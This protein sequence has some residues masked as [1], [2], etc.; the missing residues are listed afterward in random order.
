MPTAKVKWQDCARYVPTDKTSCTATTTWYCTCQ[1]PGVRWHHS[2]NAM[3]LLVAP[4]TWY[5]VGTWYQVPCGAHIKFGTRY[6]IDYGPTGRAYRYLVGLQHIMCLG[7][8][9]PSHH[10]DVWLQN[11]TTMAQVSA[12]VA[13]GDCDTDTHLLIVFLFSF[14]LPLFI[15]IERINHIL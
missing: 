6:H 3:L 13:P 5:Q 1:K 10:H 15:S 12:H 7:H 11:K 4:C 2:H 9:D 14:F 8:P